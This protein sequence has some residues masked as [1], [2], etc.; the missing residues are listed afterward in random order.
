MS[1]G[2][3]NI[4]FGNVLEPPVQH[5]ISSWLYIVLLQWALFRN[6]LKCDLFYKTYRHCLSD[7]LMHHLQC[8]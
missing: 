5:S 8:K 2:Q 7:V 3:L 6:Q 1:A 4:A